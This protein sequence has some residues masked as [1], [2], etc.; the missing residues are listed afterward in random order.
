MLTNLPADTQLVELEGDTVLCVPDQDFP[1]LHVR[2][3]LGS[4]GSTHH[5]GAYAQEQRMLYPP[6]VTG[7]YPQGKL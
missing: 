1:F 2:V 6:H 4:G 7:N 5:L 3:D